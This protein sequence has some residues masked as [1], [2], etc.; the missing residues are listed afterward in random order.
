MTLPPRDL[1][2]H[3]LVT[4]LHADTAHAVEA[5][6][7]LGSLAVDGDTWL[8]LC[9]SIAI[10]AAVD[11]RTIAPHPAGGFYGV[12]PIQSAHSDEAAVLANQLIAASA[13]EDLDLNGSTL[14]DTLGANL[15]LT[16][17]KMIVIKA[18]DGNTNN[19]VYKPAAANGFLGPLGA[20]AN[21]ITLLPGQ[22]ALLTNFSAAGWTVTP[23]TADLINI[24]NSGAGTTVTYDLLIVGF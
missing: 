3:R 15:A 17:V 12:D 24:A 8:W 18:A 19:V 22:V 2:E 20:A 9:G 10:S 6:H 16:S 13:N 5:G 11:T 23:G 21:T 14:Q 1:L 7:A 4:Y